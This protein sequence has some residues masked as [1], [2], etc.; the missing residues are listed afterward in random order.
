MSRSMNAAKQGSHINGLRNCSLKLKMGLIL[1][2]GALI[3][4]CQD[5]YS[6]FTIYF[7]RALCDY[8]LSGIVINSSSV[9]VSIH[10][11]RVPISIIR[12][13]L[14]LKFIWLVIAS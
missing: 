4:F 11:D 6:Y 1:Q 12:D 8:L 5:Q 2:Q 3:I 7:K 10:H 9:I 14:N 13:T